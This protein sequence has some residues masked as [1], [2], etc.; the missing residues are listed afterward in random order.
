MRGRQ[1]VTARG[2]EDRRLTRQPE[3]GGGSDGQ[4]PPVGV[5]REKIK[6]GGV[7]HSCAGEA[8]WAASAGEADGLV[9]LRARKKGKGVGP[10][11]L[12]EERGEEK[13]GFSF[14]F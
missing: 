7:R 2:L 3:V 8:S 4:A 14:F 9:S 1:P 10:A 12:R 11:G 13:K 5:W 6:G